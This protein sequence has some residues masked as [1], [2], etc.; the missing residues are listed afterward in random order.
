MIETMNS[1]T[2][3]FLSIALVLF[4]IRFVYWKV[5]EVKADREKP[6]KDSAYSSK[7][8]Y[9]TLLTFIILL[10]VIGVDILPF[11]QNIIV[12]GFGLLLVIVGFVISMEARRAI[13]IN[14]THAAE[15]QI[16][17]NHE[18]VTKSV[19]AYIR[20]PIYAGIFLSVIGI[21]L[22]L[23][24]YLVLVLL[25]IA[26]PVMQYQAHLEETILTKHFGEQYK[27]YKKRTRRFLPFLW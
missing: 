7:R 25:F 15:Y 1:T 8:I 11:A 2:L 9:T 6:R 22:I 24:S 17:K 4:G 26:I 13:G 16:K 3:I 21:E 14:W 5:T 23:S 10:Q 18:L 20:H 27:A 12:Q 19:Y